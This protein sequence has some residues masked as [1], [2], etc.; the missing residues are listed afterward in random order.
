ML[1]IKKNENQSL[2]NKRDLDNLNFNYNRIFDS[3]NV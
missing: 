3:E 2:N 1:Y